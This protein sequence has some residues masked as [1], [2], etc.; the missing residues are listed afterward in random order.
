VRPFSSFGRLRLHEDSQYSS[1]IRGC[2]EPVTIARLEVLGRS[3]TPLM[4]G[5]EPAS[6]VPRDTR[7]V[8]P[9]VAG[10]G[11]VGE[12]QET[13]TSCTGS[14][15]QCRVLTRK[16]IAVKGWG[17][18]GSSCKALTHRDHGL[19]FTALLANI[20]HQLTFRTHVLASCRPSHTSLPLWKLPPE[21]ASAKSSLLLPVPARYSRLC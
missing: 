8:R 18:I 3:K 6:V 21:D 11:A 1:S 15:R 5:I 7:I 20:S 9:Y 4:S 19:V 12:V 2:I 16:G 17:V 13:R 14:L 10:V